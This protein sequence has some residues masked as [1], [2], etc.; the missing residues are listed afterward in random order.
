MERMH[1][2]VLFLF[3]LVM[4]AG[5][6]TAEMAMQATGGEKGNVYTT[7]SIYVESSPPGASAVLDGGT[8]QLVTPGTLKAVQPGLHVVTITKPGY[9]PSVADVHVSAGATQ[10]V[11]VTLTRVTDPGGISVSSNPRGAGLSVDGLNQGI[12]NQ[13]IGNLAPGPHRVT[14]SQAGYVV[15]SETV[16]AGQVTP[17]AATLVQEVNPDTGDLQVSSTPPGASVY[18][19]G[20]YQGSTPSKGLLDISDLVPGSYTLVL[21][22]SGYQDYTA[23]VTIEA[24]KTVQIIAPLQPA[25]HSVDTASVDVSS[26]PSGADVYVNTAFVGITPLSFHDVPAGP[27]TVE[28]RMEGYNP[29]STTGQVAA[30]QNIQIIAALSPVATPTR[31]PSGL[32][33]VLLALAIAGIGGFTGRRRKISAVR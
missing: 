22:R 19:N 14:I 15:W 27:Y 12:T 5:P 23:S 7:G 25:A 21:K 26:T 33:P 1:L 4:V 18:I 9:Q 10:R 28:I 11:V 16:S 24:G 6:A 17:V 13:I 31:A 2:P 32:V 20:D 3:L 8:D 30:G 29:F